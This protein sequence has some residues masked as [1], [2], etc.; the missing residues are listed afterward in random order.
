MSFSKYVE[1]KVTWICKSSHPEVFR[2]KV[3][4]EI[5]QNSQGNTCASLFFNKVAGWG[6][7]LLKKGPW[8][9][10]FPV[11][12]EK[13]LRTPFLTEHLRWLLLNLFS[14]WNHQKI[15]GFVMISVIG[16]ELIHLNLFD[17]RIE[18]WRPYLKQP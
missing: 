9:R 15:Y 5:L 10:C 1:D 12:I 3:F 16:I 18:I 2:K 4:L 13:F 14:T 11:N 8:H 17:I 7:T 6:L